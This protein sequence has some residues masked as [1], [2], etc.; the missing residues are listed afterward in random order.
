MTGEDFAQ[1]RKGRIGASDVAA[2]LTGIFG[3]P[4][5]VI[6]DKLGLVD[7]QPTPRMLLG[8]SLEDRVIDSAAALLGATVTGR[9]VEVAHPDLPWLVATCDAVIVLDGDD[10][11]LPLEVKTTSNPAGYPADYLETQLHT[12]MLCL[13]VGRGFSAVRNLATGDLTVTEHKEDPDLTTAV[14]HMARGL[15]EYLVSGQIPSPAF[16]ADTDLWNRLH[17]KSTAATVV[18]PPDL[19]ADLVAARDE[20]KHAQNQV[21]LLEA[22]VKEILGDAESG[23]VDGVPAVLWR[24]VTSRRVDVKALQQAEPEIADRYRTETQMRRFTLISPIKSGSQTERENL[25]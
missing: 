21:D 1:R 7:K 8:L 20:A 2:A 4:A 10:D 5:A 18:L 12:Q 15:W 19:V 22:A 24:T 13:G 6:A 25:K 16:P 11:R 14:I 3:S 17:P 9:Q 23:L